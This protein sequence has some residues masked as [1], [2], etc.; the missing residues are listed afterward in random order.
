MLDP[1]TIPLERVDAPGTLALADLPA[2]TLVLF[3]R[4]L[5]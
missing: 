1:L 4:H 3:L 2:P 5:A